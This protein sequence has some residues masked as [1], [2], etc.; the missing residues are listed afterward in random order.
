MISRDIEV[1]V[2]FVGIQPGQ[3]ELGRALSPPVE[4]ALQQVIHTLAE[5]FP[6]SA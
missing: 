1:D 6:A 5:V 4:Q 2:Y 3:T